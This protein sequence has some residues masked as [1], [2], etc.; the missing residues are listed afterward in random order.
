MSSWHAQASTYSTTITNDSPKLYYRLDESQCSPTPCTT[1]AADSSGNGN[2]GTYSS[3]GVTY[4]VTGAIT[5]DSDTAITATGTA[6]TYTGT[7]LPT[8]SNA[9][10]TVEAWFKTTASAQWQ[11]IV[12]Q[13]SSNRFDVLLHNENASLVF[14]NAGGLTLDGPTGLALNDGNWHYIAVTYGSGVVTIYVDGQQTAT[15]SVTDTGTSSGLIVG[16]DGANN[17]NGS[18]DEVAVYPAALSQAQVTT[19]WE[20]GLAAS[21]PST[22]TTGY[23]G[24][25]AGDHPLRYFRFGETSGSFAADSSGNCTGAY[26]TSLASRVSGAIA[27]DTN[28]ALGDASG[29]GTVA[30]V[31]GAGLPHQATARSLEAW[32]KTSSASR[33]EIASYGSSNTSL[34]FDPT[35]VYFAVA[36]TDGG[37]GTPYALNDNAWHYVAATYDGAGNGYVYL[38]G[39]QI[40]SSSGYGTPTENSGAALTVGYDSGPHYFVGSIDELAIYSGTNTLTATKANT[41]WRIGVGGP[42]CSSAP[43]TGYAGTVMSHSPLRFYRLADTGVVAADSSGNCSDG[44][45][46]PSTTLN[47]NV[48]GAIVTDPMGA[49]NRSSGGGAMAVG[50]GS[51]L[52]SGAGARTVEV[53]F[54]TTTTGC[55]DLVNWGSALS[56]FGLNLCNGGVAE[57]GGPSHAESYADGAWHFLVG[58]YDGTTANLYY[59]TALVGTSTVTMTTP[60]GLALY[61]G[62]DDWPSPFTGSLDDVAIF[63]TALTGAQISAQ[64]SAAF[65]PPYIGGETYGG[66]TFCLPCAAYA[67]G[68]VAGNG[69]HGLA[70]DPVDTENGNLIE[71]TTDISISGRSYP[72]AFRRTYN[73]LA[74]ATN[75]PLGYGWQFNAGAS[76]TSAGGN[77]VVTEENGAQATF[78]PSGSNWVPQNAYFIASLTHNGDGTWSYTRHGQDTLK[79]NSSGQLT[80]L[81]DLNGYST[82]YTYAGAPSYLT[83]ITDVSGRTLGIGW[84]STHTHI[85]SVTDANVTPNRVVSYQYNDSYGDLTDVIDV[86][87]GHTQF[88][89]NSSHQLTNVKDARCYA[90]GTSCNS[91]HGV[92]NTYGGA[93]SQNGNQVT[94]QVDAL[95]RATYFDY[96]SIPGA[97]KVT[98]P[99]ANIHV[100]YYA[101]GLKVG[102]ISG[103]GTANQAT[104]RY[105]YDAGTLV[106]TVIVD[107]NNNTT[108]KTVDASGNILTVTDALGN[109]T[110]NTYNSFNELLTSEDPNQYASQSNGAT[111]TNTYDPVH[112]DLTSTSRPLAGTSYTQVTTYRHQDANHPGDVTSMVDADGN[113]WTYV[114]DQYGDRT[115]TVDPLGNRNTAQ[116]NADGWLTA[117]YTAK[118]SAPVATQLSGGGITTGNGWSMALR[119]DG[120]P[121]AWG[122]NADGETGNGT[123]TSPVTSPGQVCAAGQSA[124]CSQFF[125]GATWVA[126][127]KTHGLAG[128]S[129]GSVWAWGN[130][131][132][133]QLGTGNTTNSTVPVQVTGLSGLSITAVQAGNSV[134]AALTSGGNVYTWG[135]GTD[136]ELGNGTTTGTQKT[137]AD[138]CAPGTGSGCTTYL[139]GITAIA[140]HMQLMVALKSDGTVWTWGAG[141]YGALGNGGTTNSSLPVEVCAPGQTAPCTSFLSGIVA[142]AAGDS[143]A[144]ALKSDGTVYVWG[145]NDKGQQALGSTDTNAH[146]IPTQV[147]GISIGTTIAAGNGHMLVVLS[148]GTMRSWGRNEHGQLGIGAV[149][150]TGCSCRTSVQTVSTITQ[151]AS[152]AGGDTS[153]LAVTQNGNTWSWGGDAH[154]ELG[155]GT[156]GTTNYPT[157]ATFSGITGTASSS[158]ETQY[159]YNPFGEV[160]NVTDPLNHVTKKTYDGDGNLSTYQDGNQ[161][162]QGA[163]TGSPPPCTQYTYDLDNELTTTTRADGTTNV[164]DYN[165]DGTVAD[166]K[167]GKSNAILTYGYNALAQAT[168]Q[169][170][171]LNNETDFTYDGVGNMLTKQSAGGSCPS[172][173]C[174]TFT[175]DAG[176]ELKTITYSDGSTPNVTNEAYDHDGQRT[177]MADG[178]GTSA[179]VWDSLH[180]LTSYTNGNSTQ[181]QY[182][183]NLRNLPTTITYP[184]SHNVTE[185][186]DNAGRWTSTTD[187]NSKQVAYGYDPNSNLTTETM[188]TTGTSVVDTFGFNNADQMSSVSSAQGATSIFS[189]TYTRD[190]AGQLTSDSSATTNQT[191]YKYTALNQTCYAGSSTSSACSSPPS[192]SQPFAFDAADNVTTFGANT[193]AFNAADQLCWVYAGSS[194]NACASAPPGSTTYNY[195]ARGDRTSSVPSSGSATCYG[196][197]LAERLT[198]VTTGT[199]SNCSTPTTVGTYGYDGDGNRESKTVSGTT[200]QYLWGNG[201]ILD[202]K[203]GS[204]SPTYYFYGPG[205]RPV[206]QI[207]P[208][209]NA[210][211]YHV[212]QI[213]SVRAVTNASGAVDATFTYD[214]YGNVNSNTNPGS[215]TNNLRYAGQYVDPE[216]GLYQ[217]RARY[218]DPATAQFMSRDPM[219]AVTGSPY[220][221]VGDNPLN[222]SDPTGDNPRC[223]L[224]PDC[225]D[226]GA[227][228]SDAGGSM[229]AQNAAATAPGAYGSSAHAYSSALHIPCGSAVRAHGRS[230]RTSSGSSGSSTYGTNYSDPWAGTGE[231]T[232][233]ISTAYSVVAGSAVVV[234]GGEMLEAGGQVFELIGT[235]DVVTADAVVAGTLVSAT[236]VGLLVVGFTILAG[237]QGYG[238]LSFL[239]H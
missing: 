130:N 104:W 149:D 222:G 41:H 178:T 26:Y 57:R 141:S 5:G 125:S 113:V 42:A 158:Y 11:T 97:T 6:V 156:S 70:A 218:Y 108:T 226:L 194:T 181:V 48:P 220:A 91:G 175:Y 145:R 22:P 138:V 110:V 157:P 186:Y 66:G 117:S 90:A 45:L 20:T 127:G 49:L 116:F 228:A 4:G 230:N 211:Y 214:P 137:P 75:G 99:K 13:G 190:N 23:A 205:G 37:Y 223:T 176:S 100:D 206:A 203:T 171:A 112:G 193:Q 159:T 133:G 202:E 28:G 72:L 172:S 238:P 56:G 128:K 73:E 15:A 182:Q 30:V 167:D 65:P 105:G 200:T 227:T 132:N 44:I 219:S 150:S 74:A 152:V 53:W 239:D 213:G 215:I 126:A 115:Q 94:E 216:T 68:G 83:T 78:V 95:G 236:G 168:S 36:G 3:S 134:S 118:G 88:T 217:L 195:S 47:K 191:N 166:Q 102:E 29:T 96:V 185:G 10:R 160:Q 154:G 106:Q 107:P 55:M 84:D 179:W 229:A 43:N 34:D 124:P 82:T 24:T 165:A 151:V 199:G 136:G 180:R 59:D 33:Q 143:S 183:Y 121:F 232:G 233:G 114:Y 12:S 197:D 207:D 50:S 89:Y 27:G 187:W 62:S 39:Q 173:G 64:Y 101:D 144:M 184:G 54:T 196:Y 212:D 16:S 86:N 224:G 147:S 140:N 80:S 164:T 189:A 201:L 63:N 153:S 38:D 131:A 31:S 52:P 77:E 225:S 21:C 142:I 46:P 161:S 103:Y 92:V 14:D 98:D 123:T 120:A 174:T 210:H 87:N 51:G 61:M 111:T 221:Y 7:A 79:F 67:P 231:D 32:V 17:L 71:A 146:S 198:S 19:H 155:N 162:A 81:T 9:A 177:G 119:N 234:S 18:I 237:S 208:S 93:N 40:G 139:S 122:Y 148:D 209:G 170:D 76:L 188:P 163:C 1:T 85:T 58:T 25:V 135:R 2:S 60:S 192:G 129:D 235:T 8:A 204:A 35:H 169:K 69:L 109:E